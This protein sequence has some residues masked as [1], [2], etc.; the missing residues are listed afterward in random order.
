MEG[1]RFTDWL[2]LREPADA[3]ARSRSLV[4]DVRRIVPTDDLVEVHD[5][6]CGTGAMGRWL[7]PRLV[8]TQHWVLHD[9]DPEVLSR[10]EADPPRRAADGAPVTVDI[11][12]HDITQLGPDGLAGATI[13]TASALLDM[14]TVDHVKRLVDTC[15][16]ADCPVLL[17]MSVTGRVELSPAETFDQR[18]MAA[19]N[20]HQRRTTAA[21]TLLGPEAARATVDLFAEYGHTVVTRPSP[22]RLGPQHSGLAQEWF[23]GWLDAACE[24]HPELRDPAGPYGARRRAQLAADELS[25]TVHHVDLL[26]RPRRT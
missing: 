4:D 13:V 2:A 18:V 19:F 23:A 17:T 22:W 11:R 21:G 14:L 8:G 9:H 12:Q 26:A 3:A 6:G 24:Q 5:L 15:V 10:A 20:E 7:A 16:H 1:T 25:I